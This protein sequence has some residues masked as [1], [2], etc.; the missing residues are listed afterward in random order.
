MLKIDQITVIKFFFSLK[1]DIMCSCMYNEIKYLN[2]VT[3]FRTQFENK[4]KCD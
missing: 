1:S 4:L 2:I 3:Q